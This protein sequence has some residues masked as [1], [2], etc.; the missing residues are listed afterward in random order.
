M[1]QIQFGTDGWRAVIAE[2]FTYDNVRTVVLAIA[3]YVVRAEKPGS[4]V[5]IGYDTR[6][7]SERFA[8]VAAE[9][10]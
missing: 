2:D 3:R 1:S 5:L 4:G 10:N 8:R 9:T 7:G 6:F